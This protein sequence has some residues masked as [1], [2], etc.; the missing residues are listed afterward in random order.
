MYKR[1]VWLFVKA[2]ISDKK[3]P[4]I[5]LSAADVTE[6]WKLTKQLQE[7]RSVLQKRGDEL[8]E[9]IENVQEL[10]R[11]EETLRIKSHF[12]DIL[13]QRLADVYKRQG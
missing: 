10:C 12:H 5:Q 3:H 13:G 8:K 11:E 9:M 2:E 7:Q 1:Q 4:Y 6:Q